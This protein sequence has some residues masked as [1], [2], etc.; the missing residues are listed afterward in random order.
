MVLTSLIL[1]S[2]TLT[3]EFSPQTTN[4]SVSITTSLSL[5]PTADSTITVN[6]QVVTSGSSTA[7]A[8]TV[9][10]NTISISA[11]EYTYILSV[12][13]DP[14]TY[15]DIPNSNVARNRVRVSGYTGTESTVYIQ[16]SVN[17]KTVTQIGPIFTFSNIVSVVIPGSIDRIWDAAFANCKK[18]TTILIPDTVTT[19][20]LNLF[21]G[22]DELSTVTLPSSCRNIPVGFFYNCIG[23]KT[24]TIP[25]SVTGIGNYAFY[26]CGLTSIHIPSSVIGEFAFM[27]CTSLTSIYIPK[28]RSIEKNTFSGCIN[29]VSVTIPDSVVYIRAGAF[30]YCKIST[31]TM[32]SVLEIG[33]NA[34]AG[35][36]DLR[37]VTIPSVLEIGADAFAGCIDLRSVTIPSVTRIE[38]GAFFNCRIP[39]HDFSLNT[40]SFSASAFESTQAINPIKVIVHCHPQ[41]I[42]PT[43]FLNSNVKYYTLERKAATKPVNTTFPITMAG[44]PTNDQD[45]EYTG[46][47]EFASV[48][49]GIVT[50]LA[51]GQVTLTAKQEPSKVNGKIIETS[52]TVLN[53]N[54]INFNDI[55]ATVGDPVILLQ[56]TSTNTTGPAIT[57]EST[58]TD[59]G[60]VIGNML[61]I[62]GKGTTNIKASQAV[63]SDYAEADK[64]IVLTVLEFNTL[65]YTPLLK[66]VN[67]K[68]TP[69]PIGQNNTNPIRYTSSDPEIAVVTYGEVN[70]KKIGTVTLTAT[71]G[72]SSTVSGK[73]VQI[74]LTVTNSYVENV[75][76]TYTLSEYNGT[77]TIVNIYTYQGKPITIIGPNAFKDKGITQVTLPEGLLIIGEGAF[78]N[79]NLTGPFFIPKSVTHIG[80]NAFKF[81]GHFSTQLILPNAT[82]G[83]NAFEGCVFTMTI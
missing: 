66:Y 59:V 77:E 4:Y 62:V 28:V 37:S 57:Y 56:A 10:T 17:G 8:L 69:Q 51:R 71:Q 50:T 74:S 35:C 42:F 47:N 40:L 63:D 26:G 30:Q 78:Q 65:T 21:N 72:A 46:G 29:L 19:L 9:G 44:T 76:G 5:T 58:N 49:D 38:N 34:F 53:A 70:T 24:L 14:F 32:N 27:N 52:L 31:L 75:D 6:G 48:T 3:P 18:L 16:S 68:F 45:V 36:I 23:L 20:G 67:E 80:A 7:I 64:T 54:V 1:S 11:S 2:G 15:T 22:C 83:A 79:N 60:S 81:A 61:T 25:A 73:I 43:P 82:I 13:Y 33:A 12:N 41:Q 55:T 39:V